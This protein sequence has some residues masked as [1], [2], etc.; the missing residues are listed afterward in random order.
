MLADVL[1][2]RAARDHQT[3]NAARPALHALEVPGPGTPRA[4]VQTGP[5]LHPAAEHGYYYRDRAEH[6][7]RLYRAVVAPDSP[8]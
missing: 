4:L 8:S 7:E 6:Y 2:T 3:A 5:T 1:G